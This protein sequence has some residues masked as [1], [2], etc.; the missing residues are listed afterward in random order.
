[1]PE[2]T[3]AMPLG[4]QAPPFVDREREV[5][6]IFGHI[7]ARQRGNVAVSGPLGIG[8]TSLLCRIADATVAE[9]HS[10]AVPAFEIVYIDTQAVSPFSSDRFWRYV[11][12][13]IRRT[14]SPALEPA[15]ARLLDVAAIDIVDIEM[16]LD[17]IAEHA[18]A[19]V[20]LL[21][22]FEWVLQAGT[23]DEEAASRNFLAQLASLARRA[24]R[25]LVLV[26][27]TERPLP[28]VVEV[29]PAW[30]GSP[31]PTLFTA[32][33]LKPLGREDTDRL[34]DAHLRMHGLELSLS[35]V[36]RHTLHAASGGRPAAI[37]A[38][39]FNLARNGR[40]GLDHTALRREAEAAAAEAL[41]QLRSATPRPAGTVV[42]VLP[43]PT[44]P[45]AHRSPDAGLWLDDV[46]G[47]VCVDGHCV[48][49]I[50]PLEYNLLALFCERP[51]QIW[52]K[53]DILRAL[54]GDDCVADVDV[55]RVEKLI[56]RLRR[57]VES[58][59]GRPQFIRTIRGRGYRYVP[60]AA[61]DARLAA[62]DGG[63]A[64]TA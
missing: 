53:E 21:D 15:A 35:D 58:I 36:D 26:I 28:E 1:M 43:S 60:A 12:H 7:T 31:F 23:P 50:T 54:W 14:A 39:A 24:P 42:T 10:A 49:G 61:T 41:E 47:D 6:L 44:A 22:E 9:C 62:T 20:L 45:L 57:K 27:A 16:F 25:A 56:S 33:P 17:G 51:N 46:T 55:T 11:A 3:V 48:P 34:L 4:A 32:I 63:L 59:P 64:E 37:R 19:L 5:D 52:G 30:R 40:A 38:A 8:K 13:L 18:A 29:V 2:H